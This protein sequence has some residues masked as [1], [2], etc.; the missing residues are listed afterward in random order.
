MVCGAECP[1][2]SSVWWY[3]EEQRVQEEVARISV[4]VSDCVQEEVA[5]GE[6]GVW[7]GVSWAS[8]CGRGVSLVGQCIYWVRIPSGGVS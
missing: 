1:G 2:L 5:L 7:E 6:H 3:Q 4:L 8:R